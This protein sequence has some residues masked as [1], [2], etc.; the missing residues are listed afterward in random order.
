MLQDQLEPIQEFNPEKQEPIFI[1][2]KTNHYKNG[3]YHVKEKDWGMSG[4]IHEYNDIVSVQF[5]Q[6]K[7]K[8]FNLVEASAVDEKQREAMKGLIK[9]FCNQQYKNVIIDLSGWMKRMGFEVEDSLWLAEPS[10][11][12]NQ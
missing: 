6:L 10:E 7:G 5:N 4:T 8:L 2:G 9:G 1:I 3:I 12:L 11:T